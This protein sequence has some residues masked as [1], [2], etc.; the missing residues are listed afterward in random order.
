M[1]EKNVK[2]FGDVVDSLEIQVYSM[3]PIDLN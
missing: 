3:Q 1:F 2:T